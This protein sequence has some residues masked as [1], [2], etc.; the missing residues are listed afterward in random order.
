MLLFELRIIFDTTHHLNY[1]MRTHTFLGLTLALL[2]LTTFSGFTQ[3]KK[4]I[5]GTVLSASTKEPLSYATVALKKLMIGIVTNEEGRF[6]LYVPEDIVDDT[7]VVSYF[8]FKHGLIALNNIRSPLEIKLQSSAIELQEVVVRPSPPEHYIRMAMRIVNLNYPKTPFQT[9]AYYREKILEN[10]NL[11]RCDEG[12]FKSYYP[13]FLDSV[14][15]QHQLMLLRS[16]ENIQEVAFMSKERKKKEEKKKKKGKTE[17]PDDPIIDLGESFGGPQDLLL[18]VNLSKEP[19]NYLDT[20]AFKRYNYS[21]AKSTSY[22]NNELM[23]INFSSKGK[24]EHVRE[25][26]KI[27]IDLKSFAIV[28]LESSGALVI[29]AIIQPILFMYGLGLRDPSF[30]KKLDFQEIKGKWYPKNIQNNITL[31]LTNRHWFKPDEHSDFE[32]EQVFTVNEISI[33]KIKSIAP[34]KRFNGNK[35]MKSQVYNDEGLSW[36]GINII[37]K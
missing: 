37:K 13:N 28:K 20:T 19:E 1:S 4:L 27:Y 26:G 14:K 15:S 22:N 6:D 11:I 25:S 2:L 30:E 33:E 29:P 16:A 34:A 24:V 23:V 35:E 18:G 8:G 21:F 36:E 12:I 17:D 10:K 32:I 5:S 31:K 9:D 3:N 7:L